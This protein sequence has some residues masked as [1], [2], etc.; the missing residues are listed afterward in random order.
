MNSFQNLRHAELSPGLKST[1]S[2]NL[3]TPK[4]NESNLRI[5]KTQ[6]LSS[7]FLGMQT[8]FYLMFD[9]ALQ[10]M[11]NGEGQIK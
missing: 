10:K 7:S 4:C 8:L 5:Q 1:S 11:A 3:P 9:I 2:G 6:N